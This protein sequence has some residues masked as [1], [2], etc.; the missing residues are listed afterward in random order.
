MLKKLSLLFLSLL[1]GAIVILF[2][3]YQIDGIA[4]TETE[5]FLYSEDFILTEEPDG[6]LLF[7]P[8]ADNGHGIVIMHGAV[9]MPKSYAKSAAYFAQQG[10]TVYLPY[11]P[12]R[13]SLY[14]V[15]Q[16]AARL[17]SL[18][19][20]EWFFIGHSMGGLSSLELLSKHAIDV[21]AIALWAA[22]IPSDFSDVDTPILL[23]VGNKDGMIPPARLERNLKNLPESTRLVTLKGANHK[24]F[25]MYSHQ[26]FDNDA[27]IGWME[28]ID[29]A[30]QTTG[31]FFAEL[32]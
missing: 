20:E 31:D 19:V 21:Q 16:T 24:N 11:G 15:D 18:D 2:G 29:F 32:R 12:A 7:S 22:S 14:A 8:M 28:Q 6:S 17:E 27:T 30:N 5:N 1:L 9:I 26:F 25:A 4:T 3:W 23:I 10:Y 13:L